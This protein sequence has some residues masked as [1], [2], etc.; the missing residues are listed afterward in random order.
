MRE[1]FHVTIE[2]TSREL[3]A[4]ERVAL[5]DTTAALKLA[6]LTKEGGVEI[7]VDAYAVL[8]VHNEHSDN[9]DYCIYLFRDKEGTT[10]CTSSKPLFDSF[11][12]I[13]DEMKDSTEEWKIEVYRMASKNQSGDFLTCKII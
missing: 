3:T 5:K 13:Y 1:D 4:K 11:K 7:D 8:S 9:K 10:Y 12:D 6:D 2:E